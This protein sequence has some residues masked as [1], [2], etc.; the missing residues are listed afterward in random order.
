MKKKSFFLS[1]FVA[2]IFMATPFFVS[3]QFGDPDPDPPLPDAVPFDAG[4]SVLVAAGVAYAAK[5]RYD[6][7]KTEDNTK[8]E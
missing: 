2:I 8:I 6:K 3:A 4:L 5:K 1:L 7:R